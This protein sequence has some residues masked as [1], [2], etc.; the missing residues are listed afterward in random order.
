MMNKIIWI[1]FY[2]AHECDGYDQTY[3]IPKFITFDE[4]NAKK[5]FRD[6]VNSLKEFY[7]EDIEKE[8]DKEDPLYDI[9]DD[10]YDDYFEMIALKWVYEWKIVSL[11]F[12]E[13]I[14]KNDF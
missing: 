7:K 10:K 8:K 5:F 13:E 6:K 14:K 4:E 3:W 9:W 12:E 1:V 2:S 11:P